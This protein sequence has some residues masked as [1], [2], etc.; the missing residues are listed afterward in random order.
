MRG[1]IVS[2]RIRVHTV[3]RCLRSV[4][5]LRACQV[6]LE[7]DVASWGAWAERVLESGNDTDRGLFAEGI[8]KSCR[9]FC[10]SPAAKLPSALRLPARVYD[11]VVLHL[12]RAD[13]GRCADALKALALPALH[14]RDDS[15]GEE[16]S[17]HPAEGASGSA[18]PPLEKHIA[19][20][21]VDRR[22]GVLAASGRSRRAAES[23]L[24][25]DQT[26]T[27][28][29]FSV[30]VVTSAVQDRIRA[31]TLGQ[32]G[33]GGAEERRML[34]GAL[35]YLFTLGQRLDNV[36][37]VYLDERDVLAP[38]PAFFAILEAHWDSLG[39]LV[40][41]RVQDLVELDTKGAALLMAAHPDA[42]PIGEVVAALRARPVAQLAFLHA[43]LHTR[44]ADYNVP[45]LS[46]FHDLQLQ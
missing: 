31:A 10:A 46:P 22:S 5:A 9:D 6:L 18:T 43:H 26:N 13:V 14:Q 20:H 39:L 27:R 15:V 8:V 23:P 3:L 17:D 34:V 45:E 40:E 44:R 32:F 36:V 2:A 35:I 30:P 19:R 29:L 7:H 33:G 11:L 38:A 42:F 1:A 21:L 24:S 37:R 16:S 41:R 4:Q 12:L 28:P 25:F